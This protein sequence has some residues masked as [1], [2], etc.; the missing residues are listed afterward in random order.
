MGIKL[1]PA[2]TTAYLP[3]ED[4][5]YLFALVQAPVGATQARTVGA[6]DQVRDYF[7]NQEKQTVDSIFTVAGFSYSGGGQNSGLGFVLLRD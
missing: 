2:S 1:F 6:L 5:G 4:Q 3:D 7:L